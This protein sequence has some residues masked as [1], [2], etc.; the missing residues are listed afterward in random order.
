MKQY[1]KRC[2]AFVLSFAM[3]ATMLPSSPVQAAGEEQQAI[4][5]TQTINCGKFVRAGA[6]SG[7]PENKEATA[8]SILIGT[9]NTNA[10]GNQEAA[11]YV[12]QE[13]ATASKNIGG[14]RVA[15]MAFEL[16][17]KKVSDS[18]GGIDPDLIS[19]AE[20]VVTIFDGNDQLQGG[21]QT[22]AA[23]F[24]VDAAKYAGLADDTAANAPGATFPAKDGYAKDKTVYSKEWI[25]YHN[26][27]DQKQ[28][29][30]F[31]VTDWVK[32]AVRNG[33]KY[34]IYRLQTVTAGYFI[35]HR[36][37]TNESPQLSITT[38]TEEE[39]VAQVKNDINVPKET[40]GN[41]TLPLEG[42]C[43]TK[44]AWA[45]SDDCIKIEDGKAVVTRPTDADKEVT[46]TATISRGA[47]TDTATYKV[48]VL[49]RV[50][51]E[52]WATFDFN[53]DAQDGKFT[54]GSVE[55]VITGTGTG[56]SLQERDAEN[57]KALYLDG[58]AKWLNLQAAGGGSLLTGVEELTVSFDAKPD[59]TGTNWGFYAAPDDKTQTN[60][61]EH[62]IGALIN[63]GNTKI[64]RYNNTGGRPVTITAAT[65]TDWSHVDVVFEEAAT[66][67]YV[68]GIR[69]GSVASSY[70]LGDILGNASIFQIGK[71]NWGNGEYYKGW[72]DNFT[73]Y[74]HALTPTELCS[75]EEVTRLVSDDSG[76]LAVP[77]QVKADFELPV[78]GENGSDI[79]WTITKGSAIKIE[80][81]KAAVTRSEEKD[82]EVTLKA[83]LSIGQV[84]KTKDFQVTVLKKPNAAESI[85]AALEA[86]VI[87][88]ANDI[89]DNIT[90]PVEV[91]VPGEPEK[92]TVAWKSD[93]TDIITDSK[94]DKNQEA[95]MVTR[96]AQDTEVTLTAT[97]SMQGQSDHKD[98]KVTVKAKKEMGKNTSYLFAHFTGTEGRAT[99]EQ[100]YFATS[101]DGSNWLDMTA[102]GNPALTSTVGEE[103]VRDPFLLRS[104]NG[105]KFWLIAT[106]LSIFHRGGWGNAQATTTGSTELVIWESTDLVNWGEPH[107]A[108]VASKIPGAGMA[109]APEAFYDSETGNY[110]VYWA[111]RSVETNEIGAPVNMFY[112]TTRDF[113]TFTE[114][115][116]WID[117]DH[118]IIDTTMIYNDKDGKYYRASGDGQITIESSE[119][120]YDGWEIIGTLKDIFNNNNY[121]GGKLEG[122][123]F[124]E[125]CEDDWLKN[126]QGEPV[127]TWGLMCDQ[128]ADG[129]GYLPF[130]TTDL[131]DMSTN[132]WSAATDI[133]FG[134][135]KKRH[136]TILPVT[137]A[138]Y[139]AVMNK[140]GYPV[141]DEPIEQKVLAEFDFDEE[142]DLGDG[143]KGFTSENA[144]AVGN[145]T[146]KD[147]YDSEAGKALYLD[148]SDTN[149]LAVTDKNGKSLLTGIKEMTISYEFKPDR[150][151]TN[152]VM[153]AAPG[154]SAPTNN[155]E[156][157]LGILAKDGK[158]TLER[159]NNSGKRPTNPSVQT[160]NGWSRVDIVMTET[161]TTMYLNGEKVTTA[162]SEYKL[163]YILGGSSILQ[164]GKAN[165]GSGEYCKGWIDNFRI[166]NKA[167]TEAQVQAMVG[168]F[169]DR[170]PLEIT[171]ATV[172]TAPNRTTALEYR[173]TDDHTAI[174]SLVDYGKREIQPYVR[175]GTDLTQI[176]VNISLN[177]TMDSIKADGKAFTNGSK[178]DLSK[179]VAIVLTKGSKTTTWMLKKPVFSNNPVL[180][181]QYADPD[182]DYFDGKFW[183]Y[184]TTDG[185][186]SWSGTVFHA[187]SSPD[188]VNWEDE[189]IIMELAKTNPGVNDKGVQI[190]AS[191]WAVKGSA[192]APTIEKKNG[193]YY[194]YYCGKEES[195]SSSV[196]VAVAD[197]PAGPYTDK[198]TPLV[199]KAMTDKAGAGVGQAID[200]S[201][202]TDDN[203]KSYILL[204]N[205]S[206]VIAEL[207]DDMM[208]IKDGT[209]KRISGLTDFR[210]SVIVTKKD[211]KYYWTWS[212]DDANSPN[213]HVNYGV[214]DKL[215]QDDGTVKVELKK[216]NLLS[217]DEGKNILGSAHQS[218]VQVKDASG[219]DRYFMAYHRFYTPLNIFTSQ[220]GLGKHRETCID[221]I[222]F[223]ENGEMVIA[224]TLEGVS[225]VEV[226]PQVADDGKGRIEV[227]VQAVVPGSG[228]KV[229]V[230]LPAS[231]ADSVKKS[232]TAEAS[233]QV[234]IPASV[235]GDQVA[236]IMLAK[237]ILQAA[238]D[239]GKDLTV[240]VGGSSP[241][242]WVFR[243]QDLANAQIA[244]LNLALAADGTKDTEILDLLKEDQ[245]GMVLSF[246]QEGEIPAAKVTV[247]GKDGWKAGDK[248]TLSYYNPQTKVLENVGEYTL[249][250][251]GKATLDITKGGK[252]VL[253]QKAAPVT[254]SSVTL[255]KTSITLEPGRSER[256]TATVLP[257][258]ASN[259]SLSWKSDNEKV[260]AV[261]QN[262]N[263]T[264]KAAGTATVTATSANGISASCKVTVKAAGQQPKPP[265]PGVSSVKLNKSKLTLGVGEKFTL[266]ATVSPKNAAGVTWN[267]SN[268]KIVTVK[269]GKLVAKKKGTATITATAGGKKATCK[270]TVKAAPDKKAKVSLNKKSV[271]L[272]LKGKKTFQIKAKISGKKYGCNGFK[273]TVDKKGKKAVKVDKNGK[274][275]AKKKG[276]ATITVKPYNGKGKS[277][278]LKITVK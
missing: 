13:T 188:M 178:L 97:A 240:S 272:K 72:I 67:L 147:S 211:G 28:K 209:I 87:P 134:S 263:V 230:Q 141:G 265:I 268:K 221:E 125:Y 198:G 128:Y 48:K 22:K 162:D 57:G 161:S 144:K 223:D 113:Y 85:R 232:P 47:A 191:P 250:E 24:Q 194:F 52:A 81:N 239:A 25:G 195:G 245:D 270:V 31:D 187:F 254:V 80:N 138:E 7:K 237:E 16:P 244:D 179:D 89:R 60:N 95:G 127:R 249:G 202:F 23:I 166:E 234:N 173:G 105:D 155:N 259:K 192:W 102:N 189:G 116:L 248:V 225:A 264:A 83:E 107:L 45:S 100:I 220:D 210:E 201:I 229:A 205:G 34:A 135:L 241:Y 214:S 142:T 33:D 30:T 58:S 172:G 38:L 26:Y 197:N 212:C 143:K 12:N 233:I 50:F 120:I 235:P 145:Y 124:F 184:P 165:W 75:V 88:N 133:K 11:A 122:P 167:L 163:A 204:G 262:G 32:E 53:A 19:H 41:F 140:F 182:I 146:L 56:A 253:W 71:A 154:T 82:E 215:I 278:K 226:A 177:E 266:Q 115:V 131:S 69:A 222:T 252:Y 1:V 132:S 49:K 171:S 55:A 130:R 258:N 168:D 114:P 275:T 255:S 104:H 148:G 277:A 79:S 196:G 247:N 137:D 94:N 110:V 63:G 151:S 51:G 17:A 150:S 203:G 36:L 227:D 218:V 5:T 157:Y 99:D 62:Y 243:A 183:I 42:V 174:T 160:D 18:E 91:Q 153:Y 271:T 217:K 2:L 90:L 9:K 118:D 193:K 8:A 269:N 78:K 185:Y 119:S 103:G 257:A 176:P 37:N 158:T 181:G 98:I 93:K 10:A 108:D 112:C 106:D 260:A 70:K 43:K 267:T 200:P 65:G 170:I 84:K 256:L 76:S 164:I 139:K 68:D 117:R 121:S 14:N 228:K 86:I 111:T 246:A 180:P 35:Y 21:V 61:K 216:K 129:K 186:P 73:I 15:A 46:L 231:F 64:E 236:E 242:T 6:F 27:A 92:V 190:A 136:G 199:T 273:Y 238:K 208:S 20:A 276:K 59:R 219:K 156:R 224:P 39:V 3:T 4:G 213:Y 74:D 40:R 109:W 101:E 123:E 206:A 126:E 149:F 29:V 274:V 261:D 152:W 251:G 175:K 54:S 207:N 96:P 159:Y 169:A 77:A 66:V 44:I